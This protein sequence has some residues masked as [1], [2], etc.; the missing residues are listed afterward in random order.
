[1]NKLF[2]FG[3][4]L[5]IEQEET[6]ISRRE[7]L[8]ELAHQHSLLLIR[9]LPTLSKARLLLWASN[10]DDDNL[11]HWDSGPVM[12]MKVQKDS[13]NYLFS[14]EKV[15]FHWDGAFHQEARF[16]LF[17]CIDAPIENAGGETLFINT[18]RVL[19]KV[20]VKTKETWQD[21]K[22]RYTTEKLAHYGGDI[23]VPLMR[24][25]A[26]KDKLV[27][28]YGEDV[29]SD[30]NPVVVEILNHCEQDKLKLNI[31]HHLYQSDVC[32]SH[33]WQAGDL[34]IADNLSLLHGR[35]AFDTHTARHL[36][37]IQMR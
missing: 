14:T 28:R 24:K 31:S 9:G 6:F 36:R 12:E 20:S 26:Y 7:E 23:T 30:K 5:K 34:L 18:E 13:P 25:H 2:P 37:R 11:I 33:S 32:Y 3:V 35:N 8:L 10:G 21:L 29:N 17:N 16:L 27:M 15:P 22:I 4:E 19:D 1:M